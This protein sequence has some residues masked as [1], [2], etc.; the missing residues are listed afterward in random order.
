M[1]EKNVLGFHLWPFGVF[2]NTGVFG[3]TDELFFLF[4][5]FLSCFSMAPTCKQGDFHSKQC[6]LQSSV[7]S[8]NSPVFCVPRR[9]QTSKS[10]AQCGGSFLRVKRYW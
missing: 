10:V 4:V 5:I 2:E 6:D 8:I 1:L 7:S 9:L 3:D